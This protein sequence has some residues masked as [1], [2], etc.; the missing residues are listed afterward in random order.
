MKK[1][2]ALMLALVMVFALAACGGSSNDEA[3]GEATGLQTA[4]PGTLTMATNATFPPYE[5]LQGSEVVG[6]DVEIAQAVATKLGLELVVED[7]E[8]NA[9]NV[10]VSTGKADIGLAGMTVTPERLEEVNFTVPYATG[11][12]VVLVPEGS[13]ITSVDDLFAEGANNIVG[14]QMSTVADT[15]ASGDI[16]DAGLGSVDRYSKTADAIQAMKSG[17]VDC[18]IVDNEPGKAFVEQI[19]GLVMLETEYAV[20]DYA[21]SMNKDNTALYEAVNGAIEELIADGTIGDIIE[22]YIPSK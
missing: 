22:K 18:V 15:Y 1:M 3:E 2:I 20:E 4:V 19:D 10:A 13:P 5:F 11:I 8:F 12:Q 9:I 6:I 16:E 14:V 17:K 21:A 7:M